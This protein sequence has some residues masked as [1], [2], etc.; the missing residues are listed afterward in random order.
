[1]K[2]VWRMS[3]NLCFDV[4]GEIY[5]FS[6]GGSHDVCAFMNHLNGTS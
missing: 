4:F 3:L 2:S 1:M 6:S 5:T